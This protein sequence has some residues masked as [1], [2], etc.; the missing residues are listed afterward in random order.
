MKLPRRW[1]RYRCRFSPCYR[2]RAIDRAVHRRLP[3]LLA[4][5]AA[6]LQARGG[7]GA[8]ALWALAAYQRRHSPR[9]GER[10]PCWPR[11]VDLRDFVAQAG[12]QNLV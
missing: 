3:V 11:R 4:R 1:R 6:W 12:G 8:P 7:A 5:A 2:S 9:W 10:S